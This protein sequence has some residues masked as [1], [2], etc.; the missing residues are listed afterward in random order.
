[1]AEKNL[2]LEKYLNSGYNIEGAIGEV[3]SMR[4]ILHEYHEALLY[5]LEWQDAYKYVV[6]PEEAKKILDK[7][8]Y[9]EN[10]KTYENCLK[11]P[12]GA[13]PDTIGMRF[14]S[15][16]DLC[17]KNPDLDKI[18]SF[19]TLRTEI[20][21]LARRKGEEGCLPFRK[22]YL[23]KTEPH[24]PHPHSVYTDGFGRVSM[25]SIDRDKLHEER[26]AAKRAKE[27][28]ELKERKEAVEASLN[29]N[30]KEALNYVKEHNSKLYDGS[31][32]VLGVE[33]VINYIAYL[34]NK[35]SF[36]YH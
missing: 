16:Q 15:L 26:A 7:K 30:A 31:V 21:E 13:I 1:M 11:Y 12:N 36:F 18:W 9:V 28:Q 14:M 8:G 20:Q 5:Y 10:L 22:T 32:D 3:V 4:R 27:L 34:Y 35:N 33:N 19:G 24:P 17:S 2:E 6:T 23:A 29:E 25:A